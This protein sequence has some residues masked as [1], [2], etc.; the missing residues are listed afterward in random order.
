MLVST[1][2]SDY[3]TMI[4]SPMIKSRI[5][6][7]DPISVKAS[8]LLSSIA[9]DRETNKVRAFVW[10]ERNILICSSLFAVLAC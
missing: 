9:R 5:I 10:H 8:A 7:Y 1:M 6:P 4:L 3:W 2:I